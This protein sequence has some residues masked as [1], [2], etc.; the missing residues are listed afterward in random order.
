MSHERRHRRVV[1]VLLGE[2]ADE[3]REPRVGDLDLRLGVSLLARDREGALE[4]ED[5]S[6]ELLDHFQYTVE[7]DRERALARGCTIEDAQW[8]GCEVEC[9][10][11]E[12]GEQ[13][14]VINGASDFL[15][16][17]LG[18]AGRHS[19]SAVSAVSLP[20]GVAVEIEG[21]FQIS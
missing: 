20:F 13:P 1:H 12:F 3:L 8:R 6:S 4:Q 18:D 2:T 21:I 7:R 15:A 17:A 10:T 11:P 14:D 9:S 5:G 16:E 19:R